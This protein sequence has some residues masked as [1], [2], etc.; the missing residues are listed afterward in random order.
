MNQ[1]VRVI[2]V[3]W[4]LYFEDGEYNVSGLD[5]QKETNVEQN[6]LCV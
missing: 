1:M 4:Y 6:L 5:E 3:L 2:K